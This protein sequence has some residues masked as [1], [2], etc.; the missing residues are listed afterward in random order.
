MLGPVRN[1]QVKL[2]VSWARAT[3]RGRPPRDLVDLVN[4]YAE[5]LPSERSE[6]LRIFVATTFG[7]TVKPGGV[8]PRAADATA[9]LA[10]LTTLAAEVAAGKRG[11]RAGLDAR[12]D[13][14]ARP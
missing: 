5:A 10:E 7:A 6:V 1:F 11:V 8:S 2:L 12:P 14:P 9:S 4:A 3:L 13:A